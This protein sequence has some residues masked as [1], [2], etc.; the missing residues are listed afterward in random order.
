MH[1]AHGFTSSMSPGMTLYTFTLNFLAR[2]LFQGTGTERNDIPL[3]FDTQIQC[4]RTLYTINERMADGLGAMK[5][6]RIPSSIH[7]KRTKG[8]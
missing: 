4:T 8:V 1:G 2:R 7:E 5:R 6:D 3:L